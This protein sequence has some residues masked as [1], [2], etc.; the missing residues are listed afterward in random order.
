MRIPTKKRV[1]VERN[2]RSR[3]RS[4]CSQA[5]AHFRRWRS[6]AFLLETR[7]TPLNGHILLQ[8]SRN[9]SHIGL[10]VSYLCKETGLSLAFLKLPRL[11][12]IGWGDPS[13]LRT[14]RIAPLF[15]EDLSVR[16]SSCRPYS[17]TVLHVSPIGPPLSCGGP[18]LKVAKEQRDGYSFPP[19]A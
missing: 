3:A 18:R 19:T 1:F 14:A 15:C 5:A 9:H 2:S 10:K 6:R 7:L 12:D 11:V 4:S 16:N 17:S 8:T 13:K